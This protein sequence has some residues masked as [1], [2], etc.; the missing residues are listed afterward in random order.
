MALLLMWIT[1]TDQYPADM[2][3]SGAVINHS[4]TL[5]PQQYR[6]YSENTWDKRTFAPSLYLSM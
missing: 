2:V 5:L 6:A 3:L 1:Q 4:E